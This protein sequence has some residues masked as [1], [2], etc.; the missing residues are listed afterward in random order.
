VNF[1]GENFSGPW[2]LTDVIVDPGPANRATV[3]V[4]AAHW[5]YLPSY[6]AAIDPKG[7][8]TLKFVSAGSVFTL[9]QAS[10]ENGRHILAAGINN[11]YAAASL[12]VLRVDG[13]PSCSPQTPGTRFECLNGPRGRPDSYFLF[14]PTE[15]VALAG[16]PYN[17]AYR[18]D[19]VGSGFQVSVREVGAEVGP[20]AGTFY[21]FSE[22]LQPEEVG[23][24][25]SFGV[26][27]RRFE[28]SGSLKHSLADCPHLTHPTAVRSWNGT[29]GWKVIEVQSSRRSRPD[30]YSG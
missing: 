16:Q 20:L 18:I 2:R 8:C 13:Q 21:S 30:A 27:H 11:E 24:D 29:S 14:P 7:Q 1:G 5:M 12:A 10:N 19:R 15:L 3:W 9:G 22:S 6:V 25:D 23:F 17:E 28:S 26:F 4:A